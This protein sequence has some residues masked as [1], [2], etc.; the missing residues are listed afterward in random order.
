ML[1]LP[2]YRGTSCGA[3]AH[4]RAGPFTPPK[5]RLLDRVR[6]AA[7]VRARQPAHGRSLRCVDQAYIVLFHATRHPTEMGAPE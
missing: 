4:A 2:V 1:A 6:A 7:R 5:P 3:G